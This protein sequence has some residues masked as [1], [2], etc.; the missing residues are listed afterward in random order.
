MSQ[1]R[2]V[3]RGRP[4][5]T[6]HAQIEQAAFDL[7]R[8]YGFE[9]TTLSA[10]AERIGVSRRT[11]TRYYPS[12]NDI[13][14]GQFDLHLASFRTILADTPRTLPLW[15]QVQQAVSAFND[16]PADANPPHAE[17][18]GLILH[19]PALQA[20]SVLRYQ[21]WRD[22]I[23]EHIA[24]RTSHQPTDPL[25][26]LAGHISLALAISAYE[27]WLSLGP[28]TPAVSLLTQIDEAAAQLRGFLD[29][30]DRLPA[31]ERASS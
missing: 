30:S 9:Q 7:F 22:I 4:A 19:T 29:I 21:Q 1:I 3:Q 13:P 2:G 15:R 6:S 31:L 11:I 25:P 8:T 18:M 24:T 23:A 27:Q 14:W 26:Q 16:F 12:K 5:V 17:R 28:G 20:H 10:I